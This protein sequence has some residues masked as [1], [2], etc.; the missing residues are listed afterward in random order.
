MGSTIF[1]SFRPTA[2]S[3]LVERLRRA[4]VVPIGKTNVPEFG[5][6]SHTYNTVYGTTRNPYD[7]SMSA[8]GSSGGAAAALAPGCC[9]SPT[10]ATTAGRCATRP[11]STTSWRCDRRSGWCPQ[12]RR[13]LPL[14][15]YVVK[16]MLARSVADVGLGLSA[17]VGIDPRDPLSYPSD[18]AAVRCA[19]RP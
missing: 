12:R 1:R 17:V 13:T 5:M 4:G 11:T 19:P 6:G 16:G 9:P 18:P 15:G 2:D 8:G 3:V 10:A 7:L 14:V